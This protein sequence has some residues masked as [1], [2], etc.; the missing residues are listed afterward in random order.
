MAN[1]EPTIYTGDDDTMTEI[2]RVSR[3][4]MKDKLRKLHEQHGAHHL[5]IPG[6]WIWWTMPGRTDCRFTLTLAC[7]GEEVLTIEKLDASRSGFPDHES[8]PDK[9]LT[10]DKEH[11]AIIKK[12][13][14]SL[15]YRSEPEAMLGHAWEVRLSAA[16]GDKGEEKYASQLPVRITRFENAKSPS[17]PRKV[18]ANLPSAFPGK[19]YSK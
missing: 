15:D 4:Q 12:K 19:T 16:C 1:K 6:G 11:L 18:R 9:G 14:A 17:A 3:D 7:N 2:S 10:L 5:C 13:I 8:D